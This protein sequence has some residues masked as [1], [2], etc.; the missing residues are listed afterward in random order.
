[1]NANERP[2]ADHPVSGSI[3]YQPDPHGSNSYH[4]TA[5]SNQIRDLAKLI[6][7]DYWRTTFEQ[8]SDESVNFGA[9]ISGL[10][11]IIA[12]TPSG[13]LNELHRLIRKENVTVQLDL[14]LEYSDQQ[15]DSPAE[16]PTLPVSPA[17]ISTP[18]PAEDLP[19]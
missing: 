7:E 15:S 2:T 19:F 5:F 4:M 8:N 10:S 6:N 18:N 17:P 11:W 1:M 3:P 13:V 14:P 9:Y 12:P 16:L